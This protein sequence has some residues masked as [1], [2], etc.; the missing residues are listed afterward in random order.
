MPLSDFECLTCGHVFETLFK[1]DDAVLCERC[2]EVT[3]RIYA[4]TITKLNSQESVQN[5]LKRRSKEHTLKHVKKAAGHK[6]TLP[7]NFGR[8]GWSL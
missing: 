4:A 1:L 7:P 3:R 8:R 2:G 6:G 5:E